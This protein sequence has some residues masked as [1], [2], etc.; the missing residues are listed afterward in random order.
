MGGKGKKGPLP[1][2]SLVRV[3]FKANQTVAQVCASVRARALEI[4]APLPPGQLRMRDGAVYLCEGDLLVNVLP[5]L[6]LNAIPRLCVTSAQ[7]P[8]A[9]AAAQPHVEP[10][11]ALI[12]DE[13]IN[14]P[15]QLPDS[16]LPFLVKCKRNTPFSKIFRAVSKTKSARAI[17]FDSHINHQFPTPFTVSQFYKSKGLARGSITFKYNGKDVF[18][19]DTP[20]TLIMEDVRALLLSSPSI[21]PP[22]LSHPHT[23]HYAR[24]CTSKGD[25]IDVFP[26]QSGSIGVFVRGREAAAGVCASWLQVSH[27]PSPAP[28][29]ASISSLALAVMRPTGRTPRSSVHISP[30]PL[31]SPATATALR[32]LIDAAWERAH[33]RSTTAGAASQPQPPS[34][35]P[36]AARV[37][38]AVAAG[39]TRS[40]FKLLLPA[41]QAWGL[42]GPAACAA[43]CAALRT[44]AGEGVGAQPLPLL[45]LLQPA[46]PAL[47]F[48]LRRTFAEAG[49]EAQWIGW[50]CDQAGLT[51]QVPLSS[52][53]EAQ[54]GQLLYALSSGALLAPQRTVGSVVAHHGDV[55]HG[56]TRLL[57]GMRY[58]LYVL[59]AREDVLEI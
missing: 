54:G 8:V 44:C 15:F 53:E 3:P 36:A 46:Q 5:A 48:A 42:L 58:G 56:V 55:V 1:G 24:I 28:T 47:T 6:P 33:G 34:P 10:P 31:L 22:T 21:T 19:D 57:G 40:D 35:T 50:H 41:A 18:R 43:L 25:V 23:S 39:S 51:A 27:A 16:S 17:G 38:G 9:A 14:V 49:E 7:V 4:F 13:R 45:P 30:L 32:A 11:P 29:P 2:G 12:S 26:R 52:G 37:A 20:H 59:V